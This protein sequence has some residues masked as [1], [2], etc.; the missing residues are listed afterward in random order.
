MW[1]TNR[2][3]IYVVILKMKH[4]DVTQMLYVHLLL[5]VQKSTVSGGKMTDYKPDEQ[6]SISDKSLIFFASHLKLFIGLFSYPL[7]ASSSFLWPEREA[8]TLNIITVTN[9][10]IL[11]PRPSD[12]MKVL[13]TTLTSYGVKIELYKS[14]GNVDTLSISNARSFTLPRHDR[15]N[16]S[17]QGVYR[18][19][20][21]E[22]GLMVTDVTRSIVLK[23]FVSFT[24]CTAIIH[25]HIRV[26]HIPS[27]AQY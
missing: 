17:Q 12:P 7:Y 1:I 26:V 4:S 24:V 8:V 16:Q 22:F 19:Y 2:K 11:S 5:F 13:I 15:C 20:Q 3:H 14:D 6:D 18:K 21:G 10:T 23:M 27:I 25:I 9:A